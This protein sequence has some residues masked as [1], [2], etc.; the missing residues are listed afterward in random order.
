LAKP[1]AEKL[2]D[3]KA[4][5]KLKYPE[6]FNARKFFEQLMGEYRYTKAEGWASTAD[7]ADNF[8]AIDFYHNYTVKGNDILA[9]TAVSMKTTTVTSVDDWL[10][11]T[12][13][14][15]NDLKN[16]LADGILWNGTR[17][18]YN[19]AELHIYMLK[20][21]ITPTLKTEWLN[22]LNSVEPK[23]KYEINA[24]EDFIK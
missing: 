11:A 6:V 9:E 7:I 2:A 20:E 14:N 1:T 3:I 10:K 22:K 24:I 16:G 13:S 17:I 8:K 12:G 23:I 5:W 19:K 21:N 18:R 15:I 4:I